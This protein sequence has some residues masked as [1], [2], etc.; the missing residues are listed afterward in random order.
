[1]E[2]Q[3]WANQQKIRKKREGQKKICI[4]KQKKD[5][6]QLKEYPRTQRR[7]P[8]FFTD[9]QAKKTYHNMKTE[10]STSALTI[11]SEAM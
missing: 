6:K 11:I 9:S 5:Q 10:R 1:M 3:Y 2:R 7:R 8:I 4:K